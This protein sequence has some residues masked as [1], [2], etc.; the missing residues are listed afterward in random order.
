MRIV[1]DGKIGVDVRVVGTIT[2]QGG[3]HDAMLELNIPDA[4]GLE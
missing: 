3:E 4:N 2:R 1:L